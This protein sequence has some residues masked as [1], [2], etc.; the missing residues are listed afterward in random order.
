M[1]FSKHKTL[2]QRW[3]NVGPPPT[4]LDQLS[5]LFQSIFSVQKKKNSKIKQKI[6]LYQLTK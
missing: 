1:V 2:N 5:L 4:T 3:F 6:A